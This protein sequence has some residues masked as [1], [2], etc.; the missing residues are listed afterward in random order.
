MNMRLAPARLPASSGLLCG[1]GGGQRQ[2]LHANERGPERPP[3]PGPPAGAALPAG[4][5]RG[6]AG[7]GACR[8]AARGAAGPGAG[9]G[10][11]GV[12]S[13]RGGRQRAAAAAGGFRRG[14]GAGGLPAASGA[15][16]GTVCSAGARP[17]SAERGRAGGRGWVSAGTAVGP[18]RGSDGD[19]I[20]ISRRRFLWCHRWPLRKISRG[21][22]CLG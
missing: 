17:K 21:F 7:P 5:P 4:T 20:S 13:P 19:S 1:S 8:P 14:G 6:R 15:G 11:A 18:W 12:S 16:S 22:L 9:A 10:G 2:A 3:G